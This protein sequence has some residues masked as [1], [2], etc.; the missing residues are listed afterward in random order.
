MLSIVLL[1]SNGLAAGSSIDP[2]VRILRWEFWV[3]A[4]G[5]IRVQGVD[6]LVL[7]TDLVERSIYV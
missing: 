7:G 1:Q 3:H 4:R 6:H 5:A 2:E